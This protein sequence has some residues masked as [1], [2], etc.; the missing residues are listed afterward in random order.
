MAATATT[1]TAK[2]RAA[3]TKKAV[4]TTTATK[5][6]VAKPKTTKTAKAAAPAKASGSHPSWKDIIRECIAAHTSEARSGV[7]RSTIKKF[8]EEQYKLEMNGLQNSQLNRAITTGAEQGVFQLPKGPSGKVK[9]APKVKTNVLKE[10]QNNQPVVAK[11]P[12]AAK[13]K[14]AAPA[15]PVTKKKATTAAKPAAKKTSTAKVVAK[16]APAAKA[17][18]K[19]AANKAKTTK[20]TTSRSKKATV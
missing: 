4:A 18:A 15:K 19:K 7:S 6:K 2:P 1:R 3:S 13:A 10:Q 11:K 20:S 5:A 8:A 17:S 9:L 14:E 16:K 12:A